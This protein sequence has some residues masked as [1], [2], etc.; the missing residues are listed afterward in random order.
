M[1]PLESAF[2]L[3]MILTV[4][5][6]FLAAYL[7]WDSAANYAPVIAAGFICFVLVNSEVL[8]ANG[9]AAGIAVGLCVVAVWCFLMDRLV[10]VG[11]LC[12]AI[13]LAIKPHDAGLVW[14]YFLLA[15]GV[16]RKRAL[17]TLVVTV[18]L[19]AAAVLWVSH[20]APHW[21]QEMHTIVRAASAPGGPSDPGPF[22]PVNKTGANI[23]I[24]LQSTVSVFSDDPRIYNPVSYLICG[25]LLLVWSIHTLKARFSLKRAWLALA[26]VVPLAVLVSYHRPYDARLMLLSVPA[27][28]MLWAEGGMIRWIALVVNAAGIVSTA[29]IPLTILQILTT[30]MHLSKARLSGQVL[31]VVLVQPV[32]LILLAMSIFYLWIYLRRDP[33]KGL[34]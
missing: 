10:P 17:H 15:G 27:C 26:A 16:Y 30:N 5:C 20:F 7:M 9:N 23:I 28:A 6:I 22:S 34:P 18:V 33:E 1:L 3:W 11:I 2:L 29:D 25:A 24:C 4:C 21:M 12:L 32:P 14:L 8:F 19:A 31:T 13:S